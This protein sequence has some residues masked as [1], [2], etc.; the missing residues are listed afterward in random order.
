MKE[1][2]IITAILTLL[3]CG[4]SHKTEVRNKGFI[5]TVGFDSSPNATVTVRLYG[6]KESL[7]GTGETLFTAIE[8]AETTQGKTFVTGHLELLVMTPEKVRDTLSLMIKNNRIS[9]SC[10]FLITESEAVETVKKYDE[11]K[12]SDLLE[13]SDRNGQIIK[14][15]ISAVLNDLLEEDKMA[16]VPVLN[17]DKLT[18]AVIDNNSVIGILSEDESIGYCWLTGSLRDVYIPIEID[19]KK[20]S[21]LVRK[22][23]TKL[24]AEK[25]GDNIRITT[26]IKINGS[27]IEEG[28]D[29]S[30]ANTATAE[31]ISSLCSKTI[32]KTVTGMNADVLGISKCIAS[33]NISTSDSWKKLIPELEF[34]YN[35]KIAT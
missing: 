4:C 1:K 3:L 9:P 16:A 35:I 34:Y 6:E 30:K 32:S 10:S 18:M 26:E 5:R 29:I 28:I 33:A 31:K 15:N 21:F 2:L 12:L 25:S 23:S 11:T 27:C 8:D 20:A 17:G 22:S 7:G 14:R 19:N 24:K 13:S